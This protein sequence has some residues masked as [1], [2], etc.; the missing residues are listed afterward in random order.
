MKKTLLIILSLLMLIVLYSCASKEQNNM[1]NNTVTFINEVKEADVWILSDTK[2]NKKTTVWGKATVSK[3]KT[4]ESR[5]AELCEAG[6]NGQYIFRMIDAD[7]F[8]Y[9]ADGINLEPDNI[10]K[11]KENDSQSVILEVTDENGALKNTYKVFKAR[12]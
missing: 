6:D 3:V 11:I 1:E 12:L 4:G 2:E 10:L 8:F 7:S 9:S 5:K